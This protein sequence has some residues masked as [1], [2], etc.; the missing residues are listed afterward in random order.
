MA[1]NIVFLGI[2]HCGKST[3]GRLLAARLNWQLLDTDDMLTAYYMQKYA[4]VAAE[5]T[6]RAIMQKHGEEFFRRIEAETVKAFL[7]QEKSGNCVIASG[8]GLPCNSFLS[9]EEIKSLGVLVHLL[10]APEV[11]YQRI[12]AGGVPPFLAG[13]DPFGKFMDMA[14]TRIQRYNELADVQIHIPPNPD[15]EDLSDFIYGQLIE[16][17]FLR[18]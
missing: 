17:G 2:K 14:S 11:A 7:Q 12:A 4:S 18:Q 1:H 15:A 5:S 3:Q 16:N 10:I 8:G 13:N 9:D 6:P